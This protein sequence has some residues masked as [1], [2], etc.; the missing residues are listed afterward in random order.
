MPPS[1]PAAA[2]LLAFALFC[3]TAQAQ[4]PVL[5]AATRAQLID[6]LRQQLND[7]YVFPEVA[8][9]IDAALRAKQ[10][11]GGYD[12]IT[13]ATIF[14]NVLTADLRTFGHDK[15]L[16]VNARDTPL[17]RSAAPSP[18]QQGEMRRQMAA[19][20]YGVARV[21]TL[22]GN[23]GYL[24][25]QGFFPI[26]DAAPAII[27]AMTRLADSDAL[28][29]DMRAN[30][31]G[32]PAGV[33]FL[34]S[35]LFDQRTHLNDLYWREGKRTEQF[36]TD[37]GVPGKRYGQHKP[38]YVLTGPR[39]FSGAEEFSY[40]LQQLKRATL[41]GETSGGGA[42]P[43]RMRELGPHFA[44]FIPNGRA[45]NP[46]S[47]SNWEGSGV[48]PDIGVPASEAL[49]RAHQLALERLAAART[50]P[51]PGEKRGELKP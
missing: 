41:V 1:R 4:L 28:I 45:I 7:Y 46:I 9:R 47:K 14:A 16:R 6:N 17:S 22:A 35:Y 12:G 34:S 40:N 25:L 50:D 44:A 33:A 8:A 32:D 38:V 42:N 11:D 3:G 30:G 21:E 19:R 24:D 48:T 39:T 18:E 43:G 15:H 27:E 5:D 10:R 23:V 26:K 36:W 37:T 20:G 31:G 29:L 49:E 2:A 51:R 13:D